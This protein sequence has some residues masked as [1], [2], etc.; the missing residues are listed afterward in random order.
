[1]ADAHG[2]VEDDILE[3]VYPLFNVFIIHSFFGQEHEEVAK[4]QITKIRKAIENPLIFSIIH[5]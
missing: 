2:L 5:D 3:L 1:V 4:K